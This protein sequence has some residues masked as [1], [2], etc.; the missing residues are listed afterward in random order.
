MGMGSRLSIAGALFLALTGAGTSQASAL[1]EVAG[2][3]GARREALHPKANFKLNTL[4]S[5]WKERSRT[6]HDPAS[7]PTGLRAEKARMQAVL[8]RL[9]EASGLGKFAA[10]EYG[11][12]IEIVPDATGMFASF[13]SGPRLNGGVM[14]FPAAFMARFETEDELAFV[15]AHEFSHYLLMHEVERTQFQSNIELEKVFEREADELAMRLTVNAGYDALR[16]FEFVFKL[17]GPGNF[18]HATSEES[19]MMRD[20]VLSELSAAEQEKI[21]H[22]SPTPL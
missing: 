3:V 17:R 19:A 2:R 1:F 22:R 7:A 20:E 13:G 6:C 8:K 4:K 21:R 9:T 12:C 16:A 11:T 10:G 18:M 14:E 5:V 15:L